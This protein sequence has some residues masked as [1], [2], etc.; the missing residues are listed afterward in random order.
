MRL[1]PALTLTIATIALTFAGGAAAYASTTHQ[2]PYVGTVKAGG[3]CTAKQAKAHAWG[4][5]DGDRYEC[6]KVKPGC[7]LWKFAGHPTG[8]WTGGPARCPKCKPTPTHTKTP[9][10][11][12][13]ATPTPTAP[14]PTG[15]VAETPSPTTTTPAGGLA[16]E[17]PGPLQTL[18]VTGPEVW[19]LV[20]SGLA[21]IGAGWAL[22]R[23]GR[24]RTT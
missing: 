3:P 21:L 23:Y 14:S 8:D 15:T 12:P 24:R 2:P 22:L 10:P 7:W 6:R 9:C 4:T 20:A 5:H 1:R 16:D 11:T 18:P 19:L 17:T 13:T